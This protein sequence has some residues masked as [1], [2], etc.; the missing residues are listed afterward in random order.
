MTSDCLVESK[1]LPGQIKGS[2]KKLKEK[3]NQ[4]NTKKYNH[5]GSCFCYGQAVLVVG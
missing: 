2:E 3:Q 4:M 5:W 1:L